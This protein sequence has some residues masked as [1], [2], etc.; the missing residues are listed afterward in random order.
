MVKYNI[1]RRVWLHFLVQ[2]SHRHHCF[3]SSKS[4]YNSTRNKF[5][6]AS[7]LSRRTS[8]SSTLPRY[9]SCKPIPRTSVTRHP[10]I[11]TFLSPR[12]YGS[13]T[14]HPKPKSTHLDPP[15]PSF[16]LYKQI[17]EAHPAVRYTV[18]AG[19]GLMVMVEST[20][21]F[22]LIRAKF[23]PAASEAD[24][25]KADMFLQNVREAV[26]RYKTDWMGNYGRYYGGYVWGVGER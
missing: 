10:P 4:L 21:W 3:Y 26:A 8:S 13:S 7:R 2:N 19:L 12:A 6:M 16:S 1:E 20:F 11:Q 17:R 15:P 22:N 25:E 18:Y 9:I 14:S 5:G 23:F 24:K